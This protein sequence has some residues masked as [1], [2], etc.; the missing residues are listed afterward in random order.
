ML[1][2]LPHLRLVLLLAHHVLVKPKQ[3]DKFVV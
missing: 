3:R 2:Q 1:Q